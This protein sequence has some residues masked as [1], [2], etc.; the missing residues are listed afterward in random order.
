MSRKTEVATTVLTLGLAWVWR[1]FLAKKV[2]KKAQEA[3][4]AA[5]L[6]VIDGLAVDRADVPEPVKE[7]WGALLEQRAEAK[8]KAAREAFE[9]QMAE[10]RAKADHFEKLAKGL[11]VPPPVLEELAEKREAAIVKGKAAASPR[12]EK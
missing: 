2:A 5:V 9:A 3:L 6:D 12:R 7:A 4:P 1:R 11:T 8:A 10:L